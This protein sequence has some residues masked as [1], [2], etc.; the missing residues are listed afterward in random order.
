LAACGKLH[1]KRNRK[2]EC[3][4]YY[5]EYETDGSVYT[6]TCK[7]RNYLGR[8]FSSECTKDRSA[9]AACDVDVTPST[10]TP[11]TPHSVKVK[12]PI[13]AAASSSI[14]QAPLEVSAAPSPVAQA[15]L[16][17]SALSSVVSIGVPVSAEEQEWLEAHN[18]RRACHKGVGKLTWDDDMAKSAYAY[19]EKK[20]WDWR[21]QLP[22][23]KS[24]HSS[25]DQRLNCGENLAWQY[26]SAKA[27]ITPTHSVKGWY[28]EVMNCNDLD[29]NLK[30]GCEEKGKRQTGHFTALIWKA[31]THLGC[32]IS[33]SGD[34]AICRYRGGQGKDG[35]HEFTPNLHGVNKYKENVVG[36]KWEDAECEKYAA[37][38]RAVAKKAMA[39]TA[40][41]PGH[42]INIPSGQPTVDLDHAAVDNVVVQ[43]DGPII[44]PRETAGQALDETTCKCIE[45]EPKDE[46][47]SLD[48]TL[49][50][51]KGIKLVKLAMR[52][53][54]TGK[55]HTTTIQFPPQWRAE[56]PVDAAACKAIADCLANETKEKKCTTSC[57]FE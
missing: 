13:G 33:A 27:R 31:A 44:A 19:I 9:S 53:V 15:P 8:L 57:T 42:G 12:E 10:E 1:L 46:A 14:A 3:V 51:A 17:V 22:P 45:Y 2:D 40:K 56:Y 5:G 25:K 6:R 38:A 7:Q 20:S 18:A 35:D 48:F 30:K 43:R 50:P 29:S 16:E 39:K 54:T 47:C 11:L 37:K 52:T 23:G 26:S 24:P 34:A 41:L 36:F 28:L 32:A 55:A 21:K 4:D 49:C